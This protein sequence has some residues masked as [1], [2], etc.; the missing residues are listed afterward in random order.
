MI[1]YGKMIIKFEYENTFKLLI[2][3]FDLTIN[4][5][6]AENLFYYYLKDNMNIHYEYLK[7]HNLND[8]KKNN[9]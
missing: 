2:G 3:Y 4:K 1:N 5:F 9:F 7:T 6:I 8:L